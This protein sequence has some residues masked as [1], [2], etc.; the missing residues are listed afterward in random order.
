MEPLG[1]NH[2]ISFSHH[3]TNRQGASFHYNILPCKTSTH[4]IRS[5]FARI[6]TTG[7]WPPTIRQVRI[8]Y[9]PRYL[10]VSS[11][12]TRMSWSTHLANISACNKRNTEDKGEVQLYD[13]FFGCGMSMCQTSV[14]LSISGFVGSVT[15]ALKFSAGIT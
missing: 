10:V 14:S 11:S 6:I 5:K 15:N 4:L 13:S 8:I 1:L 2:L 12:L 3:Q 7:D 9:Q